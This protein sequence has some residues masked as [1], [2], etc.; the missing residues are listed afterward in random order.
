[1]AGKLPKIAEPWTASKDIRKNVEEQILWEA[2][3]M[4]AVPTC[5]NQ[6][7]HI[8]PISEDEGNE[9]DNL[10]ALCGVCYDRYRKGIITREA[11][12][13]YK[14]IRVNDSKLWEGFDEEFEK[15]SDRAAVIIGA[16]FL[17]E[18]LRQLIAS[19][20]IDEENEVNELL[21]SE[22]HLMRPLGSF[23]ARIRTAYCL[24]LISKHEYHD[25]K[26][27]RD[28]RNRFAHEMHGLSSA[29]QAIW[30]DCNRLIYPNKV[31]AEVLETDP[32]FSHLSLRE[33]LKIVKD[34][35]ASSASERWDA[36][37]PPVGG[38]I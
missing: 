25:F 31:M 6:V 19:F 20:L 9:P 34:A 24:G 32:D 28:I 5:A 38:L 29:N 35:A 30:Q 22:K 10:I 13:E 7:Q 16:A 2:N 27:I 14:R 12:G 36:F 8:V 3:Y 15:E 23:S 18:Y 1:M 4:C 26:I 37:F 33:L 11:I 21:G 17:D